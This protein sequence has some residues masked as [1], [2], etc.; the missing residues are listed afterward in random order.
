MTWLVPLEKSPSDCPSL[1][2]WT[3]GAVR[4]VT[5]KTP[6]I[7]DPA[8]LLF[9]QN[10][11]GGA[12]EFSTTLIVEALP[13]HF[14]GQRPLTYQARDQEEGDLQE[15]EKV[16]IY[17]KTSHQNTDVQRVCVCTERERER[18]IEGGTEREREMEREGGREGKRDRTTQELAFCVRLI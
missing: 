7:W 11:S 6:S 4:S 12:E 13:W 17:Q 3:S 5:L 2:F 8:R 9:H 14:T 10:F 1:E 18:G 15:Q 16:Q